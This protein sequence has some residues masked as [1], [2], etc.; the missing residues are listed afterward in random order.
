[1]DTISVFGLGRVGLV[2]AVCFARKGHTVI[3]IDPHVR[4]L[5]QI[6]NAQLPFF[7]PGLGDYLQEA[8]TKGT[9]STTEDTSENAR[10]DLAFISVGTPSKRDGR[11]DLRYVKEAASA[12]G[13]SLIRSDRHQLVIIRSTVTPDTARRVV[14]PAIERELGKEQGVS[15]DVC[16]NPEF[17]REGSAIHDTEF[18]DRIVIGSER[19][20]S[21][22]KLEEFYH[23]FHAPNLPPVLLTTHENAAL[24]KYA[25]NAFLATKISFINCMGNIAER[26]PT[27]DVSIIAKGVGLDR[28]IGPDFLRAGL[29]W[30]GSCFPKDVDALLELGRRLGYRAEM[31]EATA[32]TNRKQWRKAVKFAK[33]ALGSLHRKR[34]A[35]LGLAFKPETDDM[36]AA[37]S[38]PVIEALLAE[39]AI[40][41]VYDPAAMKNARAIFRNRI[42]YATDPMECVASADCCIVTTDW[43]DFKNIRPGTFIEKMR[44]PIVIDG[45]R[46]YDATEFLRSGVMFLA[47]GLA[48]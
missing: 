31:L 30:G 25:S 1:M 35:V 28:R 5:E 8:A 45:R 19:Q 27:G 40:V 46:I 14:I 26:I 3:G 12:I 17:L 2:T 10:A 23:E 41:T 21:A 34:I 7:E 39:G 32:N 38:I 37:V 9:L 29:G 33:R 42:Q 6:R 36:R 15:F 44:R 47:I 4:R 20:L 43:E 22:K 18:P 13:R 16:S 11:I 48:S 24:I